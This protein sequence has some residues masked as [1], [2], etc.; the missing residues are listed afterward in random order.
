MKISRVPIRTAP[1]PRSRTQMPTIR[2][3]V[4]IT[5]S[6]PSRGWLGKAGLA[7]TLAAALSGCAGLTPLQMAAS[8]EAGVV[9]NPTE[10]ALLEQGFPC[11]QILQLSQGTQG[12]H[13]SIHGL[14]AS[15]ETLQ[16][17][18]EQARAQGMSTDTFLYKDLECN[19]PETT[20]GLARALKDWFTSEPGPMRIDA[21]SLGGR[22]LID[23]LAYLA[24]R[25]EIPD[26]PIEIRLA[27]PPLA[28]FEAAGLARNLPDG[29]AHWIPGARPS[30]SLASDSASQQRLRAADLPDNIDVSIYYGARD[31]IIDYEKPDHR[32]VEENLG[33][34]VYY[35]EE[36]GHGDVN[37]QIVEGA[38]AGTRPLPYQ[39]NPSILAI[40]R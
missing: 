37:Q 30:T 1:R 6:R 14:G 9:D 35:L 8:L 4:L 36:A 12:H 19:Q 31:S 38:K 7:L 29:L 16:P 20:L 26:R 2:D 25:E 40:F 39:P 24:K 3:E 28:G 22:I 34:R 27:A 18:I 10:S 17:Q 32:R 5:G 21:H 23:A 15:P 13:L 11:G 33:A